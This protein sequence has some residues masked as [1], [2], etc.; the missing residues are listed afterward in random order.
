[1][2][3]FAYDVSYNVVDECESWYLKA[4]QTPRRKELE[5]AVNTAQ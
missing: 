1:M 3:S 5:N 2:A 4:T